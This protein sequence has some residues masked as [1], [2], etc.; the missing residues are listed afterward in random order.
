MSGTLM[1]GKTFSKIFQKGSHEVVL[2]FKGGMIRW[3]YYFFNSDYSVSEPEPFN[4]KRSEN[5]LKVYWTGAGNS[6]ATPHW[7]FSF[8]SHFLQPLASLKSK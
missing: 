4:L 3:K 5:I 2:L 1:H 7:E 8:S 6:K